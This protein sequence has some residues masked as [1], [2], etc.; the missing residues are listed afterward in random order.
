VNAWR[1]DERQ[2]R[3]VRVMTDSD[4]HTQLQV[5]DPRQIA[6]ALFAVFKKYPE[7]AVG[8]LLFPEGA[9]DDWCASFA[10]RVGEWIGERRLPP[11]PT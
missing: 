7:R 2:R 10:Q 5:D 9:D 6:A 3:N 8:V 1:G 4:T 11:A